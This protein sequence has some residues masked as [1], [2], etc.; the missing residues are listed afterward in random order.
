M[1]LKNKQELESLKLGEVQA[2]FD[3]LKFISYKLAVQQA[4]VDNVIASLNN[5]INAQSEYNEADVVR[6]IAGSGTI[7]T[8]GLIVTGKSTLF[9]S[10]VSFDLSDTIKTYIKVGANKREIAS[11]ESDTQLTLVSSFPTNLT[12]DSFYGLEL[13][14]TKEVLSGDFRFGELNNPLKQ[15]RGFLEQGS[16]FLHHGRIQDPYDLV[17]VKYVQRQVAPAMARALNAIQRDGDTIGLEGYSAD[18]YEYLFRNVLMTIGDPLLAN[19][20][21]KYYGPTSDPNHVITRNVLEGYDN[22]VANSDFYARWQA[23]RSQCPTAGGMSAVCCLPPKEQTDNL[24]MY[25]QIS[26]NGL[27]YLGTDPIKILVTISAFTDFSSTKSSDGSAG[28]FLTARIINSKRNIEYAINQ[29][30]QSHSDQ[31]GS[32]AT[33]GCSASAVIRC[34]KDD[35]IVFGVTQ[36]QPRKPEVYIKATLTRMR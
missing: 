17:N 19:S 33:I 21:L 14:V 3:Q 13:P 31:H 10:E 24:G 12:T 34:V 8:N 11:V 9:T 15:F 29:N 32:S 4:Q 26:G 1:T 30:G 25:F 28:H 20:E 22:A 36:E 27:V 18:K 23:N 6:N 16:Y 5:K 35:I 2:L 7:T